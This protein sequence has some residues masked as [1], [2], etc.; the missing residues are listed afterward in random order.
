MHVVLY[1]CTAAAIKTASFLGHF[2][3]LFCL[4]LPWRLL[5]QHGASSHQMVAS[6]GFQSSPGHVA[7][8]NALRIAQAD[9]HGHQNGQQ[10]RNMLMPLLILSSTITIAK[11]HVMVH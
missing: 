8:G 10:R 5:G 7:L 3:L 9:H 2:L 4:L 11:D 1:R 6:S